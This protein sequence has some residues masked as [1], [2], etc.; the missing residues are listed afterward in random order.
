VALREDLERI[1]AAANLYA[2]EGEELLGVVAAQPGGGKLVYLCA[3][4]RSELER[5]WLALDHEGEVVR[6]R[7]LVR[8]ACSLAALC[9]V[10]GD[11][12][13]GGHLDELRSRLAA[14]RI[15]ESPPGIEEAE[16]AAVDLERVVGAPPRVATT[17]WLD[18]V[19]TAVR[20]LERAL[21]DDSRSPFGEAM[22]SA[23]G[24]VDAL[25]AEVEAAY[26]TAWA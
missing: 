3:F 6:D 17:A 26:K 22:A 1:A 4:A 9:E 8:D 10:A 14:L 11:T 12:A 5:S 21:G 7:A 2:G 16:A 23:M 24:S 13:G 20:R 18:E 19:G 25:T 15:T